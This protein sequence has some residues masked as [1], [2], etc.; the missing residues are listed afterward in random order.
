MFVWY[1]FFA[2]RRRHTRYAL[3]TGVQTCALPISL[4]DLQVGQPDCPEQRGEVLGGLAVP[5]LRGDARLRGLRRRSWGLGGGTRSSCNRRST[6][7]GRASCS[8]SV[9]QYV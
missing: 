3:V 4:S 8:E 9:C 5:S 7:T 2:S 6:E 1:F